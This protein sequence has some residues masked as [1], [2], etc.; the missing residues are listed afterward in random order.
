MEKQIPTSGFLPAGGR[1]ARN[2]EITQQLQY[3]PNAYD[4]GYRE[5]IN[6]AW[7]R[8]ANQSGWEQLGYGLVSRSLSII[9]KIG[10]GFGAIGGGVDALIKQDITKIWDNPVMEW[11][12]SLDES[13]I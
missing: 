12:N 4:K 6:Q 10:A 1:P 7:N 2:P 9:P 5:G 8:S 11:F 13:L 3:Y